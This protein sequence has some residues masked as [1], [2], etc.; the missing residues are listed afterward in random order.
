MATRKKPATAVRKK[1]SHEDI[2]AFDR[3]DD[4]LPITGHLTEL[5]SRLLTVLVAVSITTM[6]PFFL[7]GKKMVMLATMPYD[8]AV[9]NHPLNVFSPMEGFMLQLKASLIAG[10]LIVFPAGE[11]SSHQKGSSP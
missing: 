2:D 9:T 6:L 10:V 4:S 3:G 7:F 1:K 11:V 8:K 5:R